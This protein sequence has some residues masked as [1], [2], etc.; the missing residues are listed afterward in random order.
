MCKQTNA[1]KVEVRDL[2]DVS[3][4]AQ[5]SIVHMR[6]VFCAMIALGQSAP[7]VTV[8]L[9]R[10]GVFISEQSEMEIDH[11]TANIESSASMEIH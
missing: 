5:D 6:T 8:A 10:L 4:F 9:A 3:A 11:W 1:A 7:L 2:N